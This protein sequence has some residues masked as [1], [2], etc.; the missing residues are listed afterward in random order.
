M[1]LQRAFDEFDGP[2]VFAA[3]MY[4]NAEKMQRIDVHRTQ[5]QNELV[6][7]YR[8]VDTAGPMFLERS[9]KQNVGSSTAYRFRCILLQLS[10]WRGVIDRLRTGN[11]NSVTGISRPNA[12]GDLRGV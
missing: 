7:L 12:I 8:R 1:Q 6:T 11:T 9:L 4:G 2:N 3:L 10:L 5:L